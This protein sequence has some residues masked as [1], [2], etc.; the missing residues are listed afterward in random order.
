MKRINW[1]LVFC[2][3]VL[4]LTMVSCLKDPD[5]TAGKDDDDEENVTP[6]D[7][8]DVDDDFVTNSQNISPTNAVTIAFD[9]S[10]VTV[11]NPYASNGV[12]VTQDKAGVVI[13]STNTSA[14]VN[15]VL[16]GKTS[17]GY[18]KIYSDY[19]FGL[20]FNGVSIINTYG[21]A[22]NIQSGKKVSVTL[23]DQTANRLVDGGAYPTKGDEDQKA[24]FFSE[25]Q[26]I[27]GGSGSLSVYGSRK[28]AICSDDYVQ[29]DGG[30]I[31]VPR[32]ISDGIHANDYV[33][34]NG[35]T[36]DFAPGSDGI[37]SEG[38]VAINGGTLKMNV[39]GDGAKCIK[40]VGDMTI[41][42][43]NM[44]LTIPGNAYYDTSDSDIKSAA[45]MKCDANMTVSGNAVMNITATGT[46]AKGINVD[47][48]LTFNGG[49]INV[50]T[51]G[52]QF[53]Y[54]KDDTA[55]KAIKS[56]GDL[57]IN[58]GAI[59]VKTSKTEAEGIESKS[60]IT[61]NG[62]R[63]EVEAY[64]DCINVSKNITINGG[65][66]YCISST[67]D[68]IDSNGTLTVTGG[69]VISAGAG[70]PEEGFDCDNNQFKITGGILIGTGGA[71]SKPTESVCTQRTLLYGASLQANSIL[72]IESSTGTDILTFKLSKA[73]A[74]TLFSSKDLASGTTYTIYTG[75]S[76]SGGT[77][78]HGLYTGATYTK[79]TSASSFT[80]SSMVTTVGSASTGPGGGGGPGGR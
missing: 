80:P 54:G 5:E 13:K 12:A 62:G 72:H 78:F 20:I 36:L 47:G 52:G 33:E 24:T 67:N 58:D 27:F 57:V 73:S 74:T 2:F 75:G 35:G 64:D 51:S 8:K 43:G 56:D 46:G 42:G 34:V 9:G 66:V 76:I 37:D 61:I 71:T 6:N 14:E 1:Y 53:K 7:N 18:V 65:Y 21:P 38:Y 79:G 15:Y 17:D 4:S 29:I 55:G 44:T 69:V 41:A 16:S 50:T 60:T 28:H 39:S 30:T 10:S 77:E 31:T 11:N 40:S 22:I 45:G 68:G 23:V 25:G 26:L 48:K 19:K 63:I 70:S 59:T 49:T 3:Y 32:S